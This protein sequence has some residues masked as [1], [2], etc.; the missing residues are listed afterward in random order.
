MNHSDTGIEGLRS[1]Y[2]AVQGQMYWHD[3]LRIA[4]DRTGLEVLRHAIDMALVYGKFEN[5]GVELYQTDGEGYFVYVACLSDDE[6]KEFGTSYHHPEMLTPNPDMYQ[7]FDD[8]EVI[9]L[10]Q[11]RG[12]QPFASDDARQEP[13]QSTGTSNTFVYKGYQGSV[14]FSLADNTLHG[15][16]LDIVDLVTFEASTLVALRQAFEQEVDEYLAFC[17]EEGTPPGDPESSKSDH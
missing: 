3:D 5:D 14:E 11:L 1:G 4:G 10:R 2:L 17:R 8:E 13:P 12:H 6:I 7:I 16:I 9:T 15:K